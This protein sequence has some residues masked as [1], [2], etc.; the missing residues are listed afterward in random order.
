[1][2]M[3]RLKRLGAQCVNG[4]WTNIYQVDN[5]LLYVSPNDQ[6]YRG[7]LWDDTHKIWDIIVPTIE[8]SRRMAGLEY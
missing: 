1:M 6:G 4:L 7:Q 2:A 5:N 8:D 3:L